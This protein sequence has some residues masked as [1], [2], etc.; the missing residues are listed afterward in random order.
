MIST[1]AQLE[2][3]LEDV[4]M[5]AEKVIA[6]AG[7]SPDLQGAKWHLK[8]LLKAVR[9]KQKPSASQVQNLEKAARCLR[10]VPMRMPEL[11]NQLWDIEDFVDTL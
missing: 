1:H 10:A 11:H 6:S 5:K 2:A 4:L 7:S 3:T 8:E 9:K